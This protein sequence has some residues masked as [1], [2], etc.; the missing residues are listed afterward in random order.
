[1]MNKISMMQKSI[2]IITLALISTLSL[3][4]QISFLWE[5]QTLVLIEDVKLP[6]PVQHNS[7]VEANEDPRIQLF[8]KYFNPGSLSQFQ[9]MYLPSDW[10]QLDQ[11]GYDEWQTLLNTSPLFL[12]YFMVLKD[13]ET[14]QMYLSLQYR[15]ESN[16]YTLNESAE[17]KWVNN[18]WMH[19]QYQRDLHGVMICRIGEVQYRFIE[20][21]K[22]KQIVQCDLSVM[23]ETYIRKAVE[24]FS[25]EKIFDSWLTVLKAKGVTEVD[26]LEC[27]EYFLNRSDNLLVETLHTR[28]QWPVAEIIA[29]IN[30][31]S[32]FS[33]FTFSTSV[34]HEK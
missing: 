13:P 31:V 21:L 29:S 2:Y 11:S 7:P 19:V 6:Y 32:G 24:K 4:S 23:N 16:E 27:R 1:M 9:K 20:E 12:D 30:E 33:L 18:T 22:S 8:K 14:D 5:Q 17:F 26:L 10:I 3:Q 34:Q 25:R 28:Y 15:M